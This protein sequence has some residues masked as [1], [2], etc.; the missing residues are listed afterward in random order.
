[1]VSQQGA[2]LQFLNPKLAQNIIIS[3][4]KCIQNAC[5]PME[6]IYKLVCITYYDIL[7]LLTYENNDMVSQQCAKRQFLA[8]KL[9]QNIKLSQEM[10]LKCL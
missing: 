2:K 10:N 6:I 3:K 7:E 4:K 9:A 8:P 1:M 5:K